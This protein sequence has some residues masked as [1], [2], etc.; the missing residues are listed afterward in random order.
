MICMLIVNYNE[1]TMDISSMMSLGVVD[2]D[3]SFTRFFSSAEETDFT[4]NNIE[5][6]SAIAGSLRGLP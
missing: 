3:F 5:W 4:H 1:G 2:K 6:K